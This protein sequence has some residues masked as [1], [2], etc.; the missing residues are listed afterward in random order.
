MNIKILL[1]FIVVAITSGFLFFWFGMFNV[2]ATDKHWG[3][4]TSFLEWVRERSISSNIKDKNLKI[5]DLDSEILIA[6]GAPNYQAM[7]AQC[8]LAPGVKT[9]EFYEGL[10]P[11]PPVFHRGVTGKRE[12]VAAFWI[13]NN[14]IKM[15]GMA[16]WG[17]SHTDSQIWEMI[18]FIK[19][20]P[21]M[22]ADTYKKLVGDGQHSH[23]GGG[24]H[25]G[26]E[27]QI[28]ASGH[29]STDKS[30]SGN[31]VSANVKNVDHHGTVVEGGLEAKQLDAGAG[32]LKN[33]NDHHATS[34][35]PAVA[36]GSPEASS[37]SSEQNA[38]A[39]IS[40]GN[41]HHATS[42]SP[43]AVQG[44]PEA[45][46]SPSSEQ[47][48]H[49]HA[50]AG[51]SD[52]SQKNLLPGARS[53]GGI[54]NTDGSLYQ[55]NGDSSEQHNNGH[56]TQYNNGYNNTQHNNGHNTQYNNG[57]NNMQYNNGH[58]TQYNNG[59]NNQYNNGHNT[60]YNNGYNTQYGHDYNTQYNNGQ[61]Y[62][63]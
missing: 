47:N 4:T 27:K 28:Q 57:Y 56:N 17:N 16:S 11:P 53:S 52:A 50:S 59:Y 13:I 33:G 6:R 2:A 12:P 9:S 41:D 43:A 58:N 21:K 26:A 34:G 20:M 25:G 45:S 37:G 54:M 62:P 61:L 55:Y 40:N 48:A 31:P 32:L 1:G 44:N 29:H 19:A 10:N 51:I 46:F 22:N 5:P 3:I 39:N 18:A 36:Q 60:Q 38:H 8:H 23:K 24:G 42:G 15:T 7:C 14:G 35:S 30:K 63:H 49:S